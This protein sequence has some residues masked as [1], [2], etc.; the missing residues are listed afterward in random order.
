[1]ALYILE[2]AWF[3]ASVYLAAEGLHHVLWKECFRD[4]KLYVGTAGLILL[5]AYL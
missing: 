3:A 5:W 1:M 2:L 4:W